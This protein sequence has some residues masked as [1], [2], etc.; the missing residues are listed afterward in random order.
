MHEN[1]FQTSFESSKE[2]GNSRIMNV[3]L[4]IEQSEL[5]KKTRKREKKSDLARQEVPFYFFEERNE[6]IKKFITKLLKRQLLK[7]IL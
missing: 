4:N 1:D 2:T 5:L 6:I 3:S 7:S